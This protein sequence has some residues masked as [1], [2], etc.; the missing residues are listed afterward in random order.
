MLKRSLISTL[1]V[2]MA[3]RSK[4]WVYGRS[5]AEIVRSNPTGGMDVCRECCVLSGRGLCG[6]LITRLEESYRL[7]RVVCDQE[8][9]R[10]RRLKP[11]TRA[12]KNTTT[13]GCN[14]KK[15]ISTMLQ[16][17]SVDIRDRF[18]RNSYTGCP[19]SPQDRTPVLT[20]AAL[21]LIPGARTLITPL[22]VWATP[23]RDATVPQGCEEP[24]WNNNIA[25]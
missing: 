12:V 6:G 19:V 18:F 1:P 23:P 20:G 13:M 9:S 11:A 24:G 3:A 8:T 10:M 22:T 21:D 15:T 7:W 14:A 16:R 25:Q 2:P 17:R 5:H 4:A